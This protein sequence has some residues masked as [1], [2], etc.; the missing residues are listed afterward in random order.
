MNRPLGDPLLIGS[1][2]TNIGH[3][4]GASGLAQVTKAIFALEKAEIPPN[5]WFEKA[6]S[7]IPMQDWNLKVV[8]KLTP[9]PSYGPRRV[10]I[11][12]FGYGGTNA[13]CIIDDAYHYLKA[14]GLKGNHVTL[15]SSED[16]LSVSSTDSA[17]GLT[18]AH[19]FQSSIL[20]RDIGVVPGY[21]DAISRQLQP[22]LFVWSSNG[23]SGVERTASLYRDYLSKKLESIDSDAEEGKFLEKFARTLASRRSIFPWKN[24]A[25]ASSGKE[26]VQT[27]ES[28]PAKAKRSAKAPKLGFIFTGQGAQWYAMGRELLLYPVFE[29]S[30]REA[31]AYLASIGCSW[32]LFDE[33]KMDEI[34][35]K[36]NSPQYSQPICTALQI[37]LL[38]LLTSW[39]IAPDAV[40]G[41][42]SGEIAA[43]YAKGALTRQS[44]WAIAFHRGRLSES[45][46][47]LAPNLQ[48]GMLATALGADA[49]QPYLDE[50]SEGSAMV[51]CKNS[52]SSTTI[53][54]DF[55]AIKA[56]EVK[57]NADGHFARMLKVVTAYHS[58]H[59]EVIA[60][61]YLD[62]IK[63]LETLPAT[64]QVKMFSSVTGNLVENSDLSASY[65]VRNMIS[66]VN[67]VGAVQSMC[68]NQE[69]G[70]R[71]TTK[72]FVDILIELG[73]HSALQG[74]LKQILKTESGKIAEITCLS[75]LSRG[76]NACVTSLSTMGSLFQLGYPV[77]IATVNGDIANL[78]K[79]GFIVDIP[80]FAWNRN[81][82][83][84]GES[85]VSKNYRFRNNPRI[86]LLGATIPQANTLEP[87]YR[88]I[89]KLNEMPWVECH[90]VQGT[91]L[92]PAAGMLCSAIEAAAQRASKDRE[93]KGYELR[94]VI[95]GKA[96][97]IPADDN[98]T[99]TML[100]LRPWRAGSQ[101]LASTWDE[102]RLMSRQLDSAEWILNCT[103]L[104]SVVYVADKNEVF[105]DE[106]QHA[107]A[108]Y[109]QRFD[110]I[111]AGCHKTVDPEAHYDSLATI[112]LNFS[113]PFKSLVG[114][115]RGHFKSRCE[116]KIPDTKVMMPMNFE[117]PHKIQPATL[118]CIIQMGLAGATPADEELTVG[119]IP[120]SIEK[121]FI[122]NNI[123]SKAGE[124]L[125]G[126]AAI[127]NEGFEHAQGSFIVYDDKWTYPV[128]AF[129]GIK[130][131]AL[132]HGE[133]GFAQAASMRK[134]IAS[135]HWQEDISKLSSTAIASNCAQSLQTL[136]SVD[137]TIIHDLEHAAFIYMRRVLHSCTP[138]EVSHVIRVKLHQ[139]QLRSTLCFISMRHLVYNKLALALQTSRYVLLDQIREAHS[140]L[141]QIIVQDCLILREI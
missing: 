61:L 64:S 51:A 90:K 1:I 111:E 131:T 74:P 119:L 55:V 35:S 71:R 112:G 4:E 77:K 108:D 75:L 36:I 7:R 2:K 126:V 73:P 130:S 122:S 79:D 89:I 28:T 138:D 62:S 16:S 121:F 124:L 105:A 69:P 120:T 110:S 37:A 40:A 3:L 104:V 20:S 27:L 129:Q 22:K 109:R 113:G 60:D 72:P 127:E 54:G 68:R 92:Y 100:S 26:L 58:S 82:K 101:D 57:L 81:N 95:I 123:P 49:V 128:V 91:I 135:F 43:A 134:L 25:V 65:W 70:K 18:P 133:L 44:A 33:F 99:E 67:F 103:G 84:W 21:F 47:E 80:P 76:V 102:F 48:G 88:N 78:G 136:P 137:P 94:D 63:D 86:D 118:D 13:H 107:A 116:L 30:I 139:A 83:Y 34:S 46:R 50:L 23:Q 11:N 12:S 93:I 117:Y 52:P 66:E 115:K 53:S 24:W 19:D 85:Q 106:E 140:F 10:S 41:H 87:L 98:G 17:V 45:L 8:E 125:H 141:S 5:L 42:S 15:P 132:R 59:M 6:N 39:N 96:I 56:L 14:R 114:V 9:W 32:S 29:Q 38:D 97:V 31:D